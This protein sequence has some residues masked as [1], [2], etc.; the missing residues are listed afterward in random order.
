MSKVSSDLLALKDFASDEK[1]EQLFSHTSR[2]K[3]GDELQD[4]NVLGLEGDCAVLHVTWHFM[5]LHLL[6]INVTNVLVKHRAMCLGLR[7]LRFTSI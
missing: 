3:V 1:V 7:V 5:R 6:A 4:R 2:S